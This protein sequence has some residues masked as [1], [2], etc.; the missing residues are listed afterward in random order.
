VTSRSA[1]TGAAAARRVQ[2]FET[3]ELGQSV[4]KAEYREREPVLREELL[5]AQTKLRQ[6]SFPVIILFAGVDG[7]GK[8]ETANLLNEWLDP[9][10]IVTRAFDAPSQEES[11]RPDFWRY[12][13]ALP[14]KGR[15]GVFLS[16][17]Y[18]DPL[19]DRVYRKAR[20]KRFGDR[21]DEV[22]SFERTLVADGAL[23]LKFWMHLG[24]EAQKRRLESLEHDPHQRWRVTKNDWMNWKNYDRFVGAAEQL[25]LRTSTGEAPWIIVEG[26]DPRFRSLEVGT[27]LLKGIRQ[28]L[29]EEGARR[30]SLST[31]KKGKPNTGKSDNPAPSRR[32][33]VL[34]RLDLKLSL[35]KKAYQENLRELQSRLNLLHQQTRQSKISTIMVFEGWD[36]G[37]KG[38]A[39]RRITH[40][41]DSRAYEVIAIAAPTDEERAHHYLW[42]FWRHLPRA[43][44]FT[45]FD[46]SWYGRVL[47]ERVEG[48]ATEK[49]WR[50]AYAEINEFERLLIDSGIVLVKFWLHISKKEQRA[51]FKARRK[52][53]F[54][55]WKITEEDWRNREKWDS[56]E[57]AVDAMIEKTGT[58]IAPWH[59]IEGNDKRYA[60]IKVLRTVCETL[61][62]ALENSSQ[63][64]GHMSI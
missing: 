45:I 14:P 37:G 40:A 5:E 48:L 23:I 25:I 41:L 31:K 61:E 2:V 22:V 56:Y 27:R 17:W 3:A 13:R 51:R 19:I 10:G 24:R 47:V 58:R 21:L 8:S 15:I 52:T 26:E 4:S 16:A 38:G 53:P 30:K 11:E 57:S 44:R 12:W 1:V 29:D 42:R 36:A 20:G 33:T 34:S 32:T 6:A 49:E 62:S 55:S 28:L 39:I 59:L 7:A 64:E 46:R 18:H 63:R 9:R 54:K 50:R 35:P 60:R 43:G